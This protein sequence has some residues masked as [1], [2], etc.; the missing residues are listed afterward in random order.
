MGDT[1]FD[2]VNA[3]AASARRIGIAERF[4]QGGGHVFVAGS[5]W[6]PDEELLAEQIARAE[7]ILAE[8]KGALSCRVP[9]SNVRSSTLT[10]C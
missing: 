9:P 7:C 3:I 8:G 10:G 2:R 4:A 6:P 1:R 5:T